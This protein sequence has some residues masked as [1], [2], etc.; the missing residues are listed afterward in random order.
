MFTLADIRNN[1]DNTKTHDALENEANVNMECENVDVDITSVHENGM[2]KQMLFFKHVNYAIIL[3]KFNFVLSD[4]G[5]KI[6]VLFHL[7]AAAASQSGNAIAESGNV[8]AAKAAAWGAS[9]I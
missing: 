4:M 7:L 2:C 9:R 5:F 3:I 8:A 1:D 6:V